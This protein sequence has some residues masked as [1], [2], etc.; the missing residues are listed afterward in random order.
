MAISG[1]G[2]GK[3]EGYEAPPAM[4]SSSGSSSSSSNSGNLSAFIDQG[5][6]FEGKLTFKDTV[7]IDGC[8]TGEIASEN[9]LIV[10]E[11]GEINATIRST[12]VVVSG[13]VTGNVHASR[14]VV[15]HKT[16]KVDGDIETPSIIVE[17]GATFNGH[18]SMGKSGSQ[19]SLKAV[20]GGNKNEGGDG[21]NAN[22]DAKQSASN[23][24]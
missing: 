20:S 17:E 13:V 9:T 22:K 11:S 14:Q 18:L 1:F 7:R 5:S 19:A 12:T 21:N 6:T 23:S 3:G 4:A 24:K 8:F 16:G 15:L 2:R 10:G